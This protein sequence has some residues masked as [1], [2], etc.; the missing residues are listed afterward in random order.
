MRV[1]DQARNHL[2]A[3]C[4]RPLDD[5]D[6]ESIAPGRRPAFRARSL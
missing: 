2:D 1:V 4:Q 3:P 5:A 6:L